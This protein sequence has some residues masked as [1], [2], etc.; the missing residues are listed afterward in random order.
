M[1]AHVL[2]LFTSITTSLIFFAYNILANWHSALVSQELIIAVGISRRVNWDGFNS[3][4]R[5]WDKNA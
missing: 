3:N 2:R 4:N 1:N 5:R